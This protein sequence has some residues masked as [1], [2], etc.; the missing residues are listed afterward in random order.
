[1]LEA[2]TGSGGLT[3]FMARLGARVT[4]YERDEK[5]FKVAEKN[6]GDYENVKRKQGEPWKDRGEYD[7]IVLDLQDPASAVEKLSKRLVVGGWLGVYS[8]IID[9]LKPV[10]RALEENG[11]SDTRALQLD[12]KE[13]VVKKYA[14]V[15]GLL[16]FPG[17]FVWARRTG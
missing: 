10:W 4:S 6:L 17:F 15:K 7:A 2:G 5:A 13:L 9:D 8:P 14:R 3:L 12:L 11:F 1:M 16:G